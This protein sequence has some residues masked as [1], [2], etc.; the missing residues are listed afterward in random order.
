M[1]GQQPIYTQ[2]C[3]RSRIPDFLPFFEFRGSDAE[4]GDS[5]LVQ[6]EKFAFGVF[7]E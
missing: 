7:T 2:L 5:S 4:T 3:G 1:V 6:G